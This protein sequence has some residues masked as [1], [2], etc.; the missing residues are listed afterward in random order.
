MNKVGEEDILEVLKKMMKICV[1]GNSHTG[2]LER[3][4]S[5][6]YN[7]RKRFFFLCFNLIAAIC[8]L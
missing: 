6:I 5:N 3:G 8:K 7:G 1:M 4:W 2:S